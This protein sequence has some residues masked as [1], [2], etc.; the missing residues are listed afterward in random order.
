VCEIITFT[1]VAYYL[2]SATVV[3]SLTPDIEIIG[4]ARDLIEE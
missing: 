2:R 4:S 3:V 1:V